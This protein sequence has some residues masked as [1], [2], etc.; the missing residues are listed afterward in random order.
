MVWSQWGGPGNLPGLFWAKLVFVLSLTAAAVAI[1]L[2]YAA[3]RGG[4]MA[5]AVRLPKLGPVAGISSLLA[6]L[7]AVCA[8]S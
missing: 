1:H 8:F 3:I 4:D 5:A 2:S 7:L 6:V